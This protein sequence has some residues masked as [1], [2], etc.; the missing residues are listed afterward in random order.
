MVEGSPNLDYWSRVRDKPAGRSRAVVNLRDASSMAVG[1]FTVQ[2]GAWFPWHS[3]PGTGLVAVAKGDLVFIYSDDCV[4]R[5]YEEGDAF[6][7]PG[8]VHTAYNPGDTETVVIATFLG[9]AAGAPLATPI[10]AEEA[11]ALNEACG[12]QAPVPEVA[13]TSHDH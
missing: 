13:G 2:P 1:Q 5:R 4:E 6:V 9:T 12:T 11:S 3:H 10:G 8:I 7:D